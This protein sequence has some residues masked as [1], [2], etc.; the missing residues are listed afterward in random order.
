MNSLE[1]ETDI[2][3]GRATRWLIAS[4]VTVFVCGILAI[5]LPLTFTFGVPGSDC[6]VLHEKFR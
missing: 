5:V 3:V 2:D 4:A 6:A 1:T